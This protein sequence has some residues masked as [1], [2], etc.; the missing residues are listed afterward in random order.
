MGRWDVDQGD[1]APAEALERPDRTHGDRD[2]HRPRVHPLPDRL[3]GR[4]RAETRAH[5]AHGLTLPEG[6]HRDEVRHDGRDYRLRGSEVDL[7]ERAAQFRVVFTDDLR[8]GA[9]DDR[10]FS[11]DLRSLRDQGLV[12]GRTVT[13]LRDGTVADVVSVTPA[14]RDLLEQYRDPS[15][16]PGQTYYGGW[17]KPAEVW[18]DASLHRMVR[19]V[20]REL[21]STGAAIQRV[22][23]DDELKA[24]AFRA[25]QELRRDGLSDDAAHRAVAALQNL[26]LDDGHFVFPDVRLD[27]RDEDGTVRTMD[28]ELVTEHYHRGHLGGKATAGFRLFGGSSAGA[29]GGTAPDPHR[30]GRL[31]R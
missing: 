14:G 23:L 6:R 30:I 15:H 29:R 22:I 10:R 5:R 7:L 21:R 16:D 8:A 17:V 12:D 19:E 2:D 13:R 25:L 28:L 9:G 1:R 24:R 20:E 18:H 31:L 27:V 4:S 11:A 26:P 3:D